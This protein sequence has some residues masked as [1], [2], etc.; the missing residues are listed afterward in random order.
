MVRPSKRIVRWFGA[1]KAEPEVPPSAPAKGRYTAE[2][3]TSERVDMA[4]PMPAVSKYDARPGGAA[5]TSTPEP[6]PAVAEDP[7]PPPPPPIYSPPR[8]EVEI[9]VDLRETDTGFE[10]T[11]EQR[12][13]GSIPPHQPYS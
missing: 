9:I 13:P 2:V 11:F 7:T 6:E 5:L 8:R 12:D 3:D 4:P 10:G 1:D